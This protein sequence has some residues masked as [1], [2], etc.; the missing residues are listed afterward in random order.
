EVTSTGNDA[1]VTNAA[2]ITKVLTSLNTTAGTPVAADNIL[3]AIGKLTGTDALKANLASPTFTG[4]PTLPTGTIAVTQAANNNTTAVA[5]TAYA[6][7]QA[8]A[9]VSGKQNTL[10]NS[11]GLAGALSDETGTGLAVFATSPTLTTPVLGVATVTSVNGLTPTAAAVGFTLA[12]G[13]TSKTLTVPLD[14]SVSGTNTG[15]Q[16]SVTGNAGTATALQTA[17]SIYG[18][19]F[20]GGADLTQIIAPAFG[21]TGNGFTNFTG[22]ATT[23]KIYTLPNASATI[24]TSNAAVTPGQGGT[25]VNNGSSTITLGGN[26]TTSGAFTTTLTSTANTNVTLPTT[27]TVSTLAGS[28]ALTNKTIATFNFAADAGA[29][30]AYAITLSPAP[31]AYTTGM[32]VILKAN[33]VN[34]GAATVNVNSLGVKTIVKRVNTALANGDIPALSFK[35]LVYDG[36]NFVIMNPAVL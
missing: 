5:T 20:N 8:S 23:E 3:A 24:L 7:A 14:A 12:G 9:A 16:T 1:T 34:T 25:G 29:S 33:T 21:G 4:T 11:A 15:D 19:S 35:M 17:R 36:T 27:G 10:T 26:L 31:A 28:E 30:D 22:A 6:D 13:T 2:V 18:N 32:I